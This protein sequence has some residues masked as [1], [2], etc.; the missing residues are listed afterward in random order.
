MSTPFMLLRLVGKAVAKHALNTVAFGLPLGDVLFDA[1]QE[2]MNNW[3][4]QAREE[5]RRAELQAMA[6]AATEEVRKQV[7]DIIRTEFAH[8]PPQAQE[9]VAAYLMEVP[10]NYRKKCTRLGSLGGAPVVTAVALNDARELVSLLPDIPPSFKS[11]TGSRK[12]TE[13]EI[14]RLRELDHSINGGIILG[15]D[16]YV[17]EVQGRAIRGLGR[18]QPWRSAAS[19]GC[20]KGGKCA[21]CGGEGKARSEARPGWLC[22]VPIDRN[23]LAQGLQHLTAEI[24]WVYG[25]DGS[26]ILLVVADDRRVALVAMLPQAGSWED[27]AG[28][29]EDAPRLG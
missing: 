20:G 15:L 1:A 24:A 18:P 17:V 3:K 9:E 27:V 21:G 6:Q 5:Q 16:G 29:W 4:E 2:A 25:Q 19:I 11:F 8:L 12:L 14:R 7:S 26:P 13:K 23:L 10:A 28:T 22:G